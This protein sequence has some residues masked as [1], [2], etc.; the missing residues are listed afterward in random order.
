[1]FG[2]ALALVRG[3]RKADKRQLL[4]IILSPADLALS[5]EFPSL[6]VE[7]TEIKEKPERPLCLLLTER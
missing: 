5:S 2:N 4:T 7:D 1:M 3:P 6:K